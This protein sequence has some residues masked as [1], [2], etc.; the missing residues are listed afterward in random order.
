M[1][2]FSICYCLT[3]CPNTAF[4]PSSW[5]KK[6]TK[7]K[8]VK[9]KNII[10]YKSSHGH[11][12]VSGSDRV[13][14][15][16]GGEGGVGFGSEPSVSQAFWVLTFCLPC[17]ANHSLPLQASEMQSDSRGGFH[18]T[19]VRLGSPARCPDQDHPFGSAACESKK[20]KKSHAAESSCDYIVSGPS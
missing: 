4:L 3:C 6:H 2:H 12:E 19:E 14:V 1:Y 17:Q 5:G 11:S 13:C 16:G 10:K 7:N 20:K 15:E 8:N 18:V 9:V